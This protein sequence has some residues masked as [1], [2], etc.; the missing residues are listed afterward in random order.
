MKHV[1]IVGGTHGN[2]WT[3]I[4]IVK[5]LQHRILTSPKLQLE[6]VHA[7]PKAFEINKRFVDIDLNRVFA[8]V[9]QN[10]NL[11]AIEYTRAKE[12]IAQFNQKPDGYIIDI[13]TTT[14]NMGAT[15][16]LSQEEQW[17]KELALYVSQKLKNVKVIFAIDHS[18]KYVATQLT[19]GAIIEVGPCSSSVNNPIV[20]DQTIEL[21]NVILEFIATAPKLTGSFEY[22]IEK[23]EILY[24]LLDGKLAA[25]VHPKLQNQEFVPLKK[26]DPLF[27][28]FDGHTQYYEG[29]KQAYPI[30]INEAAYYHYNIALVLCEKH[31]MTI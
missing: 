26:G 13:H 19:H 5:H 15:L 16:I 1:F 29:E 30:F 2:E 25:M 21:C 24:P 17:H 11:K 23:E 22:Y 18:K 7:N 9:H 10:Q 20:I 27:Y 4:T 8:P 28:H 3:G 14:G 31:K 12:L 6:F